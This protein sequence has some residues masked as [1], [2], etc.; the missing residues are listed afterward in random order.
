MIRVPEG[1]GDD[2]DGDGGE[3]AE[4]VSGECFDAL[5]RPGDRCLVGLWG[6]IVSRK[7]WISGGFPALIGFRQTQLKEKKDPQIEAKQSNKS[8]GPPPTVSP[9]YS[10]LR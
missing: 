9:V 7:R 6:D 2:G 8:R 10:S 3:G 5:C 1:C 4:G